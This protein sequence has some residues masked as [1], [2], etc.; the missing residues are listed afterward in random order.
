MCSECF[1]AQLCSE[2]KVG[3]LV[4]GG[5]LQVDFVKK[6][7][8]MELIKLQQTPSISKQWN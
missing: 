2:E 4:Y 3:D 5:K 7:N 6:E 8:P 1:K